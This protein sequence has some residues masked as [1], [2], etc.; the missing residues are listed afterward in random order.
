MVFAQVVGGKYRASALGGSNRVGAA[1]RR[2]SAV[3]VGGLNF[4]V[5]HALFAGKPVLPSEE[6]GVGVGERATRRNQSEADECGIDSPLLRNHWRG[7][8]QGRFNNEY[9]SRHYR[10]GSVWQ[11]FRRRDTGQG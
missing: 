11:L 1:N 7:S 10:A 2:V 6:R 5:A 8:R 3:Q 4:H 9:V